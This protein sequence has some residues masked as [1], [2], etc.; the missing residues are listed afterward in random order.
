MFPI[1]SK[2]LCWFFKTFEKALLFASLQPNPDVLTS[3]KLE[4]NIN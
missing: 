1:V 2:F 4:T 3:E